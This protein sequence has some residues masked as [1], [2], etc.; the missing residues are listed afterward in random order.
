MCFHCVNRSCFDSA[1]L[2]FAL[3][4]QVLPKRQQPFGLLLNNVLYT[5]FSVNSLEN[6]NITIGVLVYVAV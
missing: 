4:T 5:L 2:F 6:K 1:H 3:P